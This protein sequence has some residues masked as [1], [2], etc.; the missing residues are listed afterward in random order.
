[1]NIGA[2]GNTWGYNL[3]IGMLSD[4]NLERWQSWNGSIENLVPGSYCRAT[5][6]L[7]NG[8]W[9]L[10]IS[11]GKPKLPTLHE[12]HFRVLV[13]GIYKNVQRAAHGCLQIVGLEQEESRRVALSSGFG[14]LE[15]EHDLD[16]TGMHFL[17]QQRLYVFWTTGLMTVEAQLYRKISKSLYKTLMAWFYWATFVWSTIKAVP[18]AGGRND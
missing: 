6:E 13:D 11:P 3:Y 2:L 1:M 15:V 8:S 9:I 7:L 10:G 12:T 4:M 17:D 16:R 18:K 5:Q 14:V